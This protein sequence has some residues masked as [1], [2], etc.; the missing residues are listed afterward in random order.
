MEL[1]ML[2]VLMGES[3]VDVAIDSTTFDAVVTAWK[4]CKQTPDIFDALTI[5]GFARDGTDVPT[6]LDAWLVTG[7]I[8]MGVVEEDPHQSKGLSLSS[9]GI[10]APTANNIAQFT[11]PPRSD[12]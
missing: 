8:L 4:V 12:R 3:A 6:I 10:I 9:S 5:N 2:R 11:P 7:F 1:R